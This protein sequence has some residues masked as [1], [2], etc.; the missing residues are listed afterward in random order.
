MMGGHV[1]YT[2]NSLACKMHENS[3]CNTGDLCWTFVHQLKS[4]ASGLLKI[5]KGTHPVFIL[6]TWRHTT[7]S[8]ML[9]PVCSYHLLGSGSPATCQT[10]S[11]GGGLLP[12][13]KWVAE[14]KLCLAQHIITGHSRNFW[15]CR[16]LAFIHLLP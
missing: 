1:E 14:G 4:M 6:A 12:H 8:V 11:G 7:E 15:E 2:R 16:K 13:M 10:L 9:Q 5:K 3:A